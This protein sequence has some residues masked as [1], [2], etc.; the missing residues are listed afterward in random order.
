MALLATGFI[1]IILENRLIKS[2]VHVLEI[3]KTQKYGIL[4]T[5]PL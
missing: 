3:K 1:P 4:H 2:Q 5:C